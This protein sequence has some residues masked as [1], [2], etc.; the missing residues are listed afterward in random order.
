MTDSVYRVTEVIGTSSESWEA[1]A[2][3][4][5]ATAAR[6]VRDLR[7]AE[8]LVDRGVRLSVVVVA[9]VVVA[10]TRLVRFVPVAAGER[11]RDPGN[12]RWRAAA[13]DRPVGCGAHY[14][15]LYIMVIFVLT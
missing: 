15:I 11:G 5:V 12:L 6:S 1:A 7:V 14:R 4:A 10:R 9:A 8:A 13:A 3:N 2:N